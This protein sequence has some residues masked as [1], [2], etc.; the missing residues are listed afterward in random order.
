MSEHLLDGSNICPILEK[1]GGEAM[2]KS[3]GRYIFWNSSK[4]RTFPDHFCDKKSSKTNRIIGKLRTF[5]IFS[6]VVMTDK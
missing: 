5:Y 4:N 3:M 6:I 2:A 1:R